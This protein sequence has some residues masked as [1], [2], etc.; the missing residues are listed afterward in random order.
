[1][2]DEQLNE[3]IKVLRLNT[4]TPHNM[5]NIQAL[6]DMTSQ[7]RIVLYNKHCK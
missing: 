4:N 2:K 6:K 1:M 3:L 7:E 5:A